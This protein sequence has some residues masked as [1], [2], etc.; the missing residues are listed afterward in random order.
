MKTWLMFTLIL[1]SSISRASDASDASNVEGLWLSEE[2]D[3]IIKIE[4]SDSTYFGHL[5]WIKPKDGKKATELLDKENPDKSLKSRKLLGIK[6]LDGFEFDDGSW[7]GGTI[8]DP[9]SGK[10]YSAKMKLE[11]GKLNL[12]GYVGISLF[13]RT[14]IWSS[15]KDIPKD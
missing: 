13:G 12:R 9:K 7:S 10:T 11:D 6:L 15:V 14:S 2:K 8:Y 5:V 4:K 3:G 1:S